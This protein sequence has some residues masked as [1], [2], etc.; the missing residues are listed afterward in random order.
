METAQPNLESAYSPTTD[1][2]RAL[3]RSFALAFVPHAQNSPTRKWLTIILFG[4]WSVATMLLYLGFSEPNPEIYWT[5]TVIVF[6]VTSH[7]WGFEYGAL[8]AL[9]KRDDED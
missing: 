1:T 6:T 8:S 4:T 3:G 5:M 7:M 9:S 2:V